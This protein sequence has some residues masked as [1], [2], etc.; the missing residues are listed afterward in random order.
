[1]ILHDG[2]RLSIPELLPGW[3]M[4]VSSIWSPEFD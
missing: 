2:E 1:M 3:E 4:E